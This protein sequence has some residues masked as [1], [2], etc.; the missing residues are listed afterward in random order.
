MP[1]PSSSA[2]P[3]APA[4]ARWG[5]GLYRLFRWGAIAIALW[6]WYMAYWAPDNKLLVF[7]LFV[8]AVLACWLVGRGLRLIL[9]RC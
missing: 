8:P 7:L 5:H 2:L 1:G 6:G 9:A 3:Q 4:T